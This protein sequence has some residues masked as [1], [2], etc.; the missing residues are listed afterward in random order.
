MNKQTIRDIG[1]EKRDPC[2]LK[3]YNKRYS[4]RVYLT[5]QN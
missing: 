3:S 2:V 1:L 4:S 5:D